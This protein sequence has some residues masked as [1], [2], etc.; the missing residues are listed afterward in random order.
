MSIGP[1]KVG[2]VRRGYSKAV[3]VPEFP[4]NGGFSSPADIRHRERADTP[5]RRRKAKGK[6]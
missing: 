5:A 3:T 6:R 2:S 4:Q 1:P